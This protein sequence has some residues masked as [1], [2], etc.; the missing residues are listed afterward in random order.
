M[1]NTQPIIF[2]PGDEVIT[3]YG[4]RGIITSICQCCECARRKW[5][6][7]VWFNPDTGMQK[8]ITNYDY[9]TG[10]QDFYKIG[11]YRFAEFDRSLIENQLVCFRVRID[12]LETQLRNM[13]EEEQK[14][15]K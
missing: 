11:K 3:I 15:G 7:P 12:E 14:N 13:D 8:H 2:Q 1:N 4:E 6:E 9:E 10:F 5:F